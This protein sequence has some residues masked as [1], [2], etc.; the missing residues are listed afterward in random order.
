MELTKAMKDLGRTI[1]AL[2]KVQTKYISNRSHKRYCSRQ[3]SKLQCISQL[4]DTRH[5]WKLC[6]YS[7]RTDEKMAP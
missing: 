4:S 1:N 2:A 3:L 7:A 5:F 6:E